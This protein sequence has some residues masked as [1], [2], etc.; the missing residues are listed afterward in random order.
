MI[1]VNIKTLQNLKIA[2]ENSA[3]MNCLMLLEDDVIH[4]TDLV[5][6]IGFMGLGDD[7]GSI[8]HYKV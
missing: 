1:F 2:M 6:L 8:K 7:I 3:M 5:N 4:I